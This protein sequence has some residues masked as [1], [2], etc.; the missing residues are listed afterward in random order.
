[1]I[2]RDPGITTF[3]AMY[4]FW[5][6]NRD[7]SKFRNQTPADII[8][9]N[10]PEYI[11]SSLFLQ[12][13]LLTDVIAKRDAEEHLSSYCYEYMQTIASSTSENM[14]SCLTGV[15][16]PSVLVK[17]NNF[18][19]YKKSKVYW[20]GVVKSCMP[21]NYDNNGVKTN[22]SWNFSYNP[23]NA[24][25][26]QQLSKTSA[27]NSV[28]ATTE[29][30]NTIKSGTLKGYDIANGVLKTRDIIRT[31]SR[32][33][34]YN[35]GFNK[36]TN[37]CDGGSYMMGINLVEHYKNGSGSKKIGQ[38]SYC[39]TN[40]YD[41]VYSNII[42]NGCSITKKLLSED[43]ISTWNK[44]CQNWITSGLNNSENFLMAIKASVMPNQSRHEI[45]SQQLHGDYRHAK[46]VA[47][48][49]KYWRAKPTTSKFGGVI[50]TD[51]LSEINYENLGTDYTGFVKEDNNGVK[52][53]VEII[54][55]KAELGIIDYKTSF[56]MTGRD[57][58]RKGAF[59][60]LYGGKNKN[61]PAEPYFNNMQYDYKYPVL[62]IDTY[63]SKIE[64][65]LYNKVYDFRDDVINWITLDS[66][67][68]Y[69]NSYSCNRSSLEYYDAKDYQNTG[70]H[71]YSFYENSPKSIYARAKR[72]MVNAYT[73]GLKPYSTKL[74]KNYS[75]C[76]AQ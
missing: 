28:I 3:A 17:I 25:C 10:D 12:K 70:D 45:T 73:T 47:A 51:N 40:P 74:V 4:E 46:K 59:F 22:T 8:K 6:N 15:M 31:T 34:R 29:I 56:V 76:R 49:K 48:L 2:N 7:I 58:M 24:D 20:E 1:M 68:V 62:N 50:S 53:T 65:T 67:W 26:A 16:I 72:V 18:F 71:I 27:S 33:S 30:K 75:V 35:R 36:I 11:L 55:P 9:S 39:V 13:E 54:M 41:E 23:L 57:T 61:D 37:Y 63:A 14:K 5:N 69:S 42:A 43:D 32:V 44:V 64:F 38:R 52:T 60:R 21:Y 66:D 19:K